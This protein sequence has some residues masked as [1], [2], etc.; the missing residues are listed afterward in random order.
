[1]SEEE[2][3]AWVHDY[4][5]HATDAECLECYKIYRMYYDEGQSHRVSLQYAGLM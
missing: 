2:I 4:D 1:M 5:P 3:I